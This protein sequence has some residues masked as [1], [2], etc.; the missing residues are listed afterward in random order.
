MTVA[1]T[2]WYEY[3]CVACAETVVT[4]DKSMA[5][6][7]YCGKCNHATTSHITASTRPRIIVDFDCQICSTPT[8]EDWS[9]LKSQQRIK[10]GLKCRACRKLDYHIEDYDLDDLPERINHAPGHQESLSE[11]GILISEEEYLLEDLDRIEDWVNDAYNELHDGLDYGHTP[12][13]RRGLNEFDLL[14]G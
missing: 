12:P 8:R 3:A 10:N 4:R 2:S 1:A 7:Q 5:E 11:E 14:G 9:Y 6:Q 13:K